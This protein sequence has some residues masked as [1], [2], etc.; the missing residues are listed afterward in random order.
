MAS[1]Q[2]V[3]I[4]KIR[5]RAQD[6]R[7]AV[8]ELQGKLTAPSAKHLLRPASYTLDDVEM[9]FLA[10]KVL[11]ER[12]APA[13]LSRWLDY[14]EEALQTAV[15]Q[16]KFYEGIVKKYGSTVTLIP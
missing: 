12:R 8:R 4:Q 1:G 7:R 16:R 9:F 15:A 10:P 11:S 5:S 3:R 14:A 2:E 6:E 13:Q